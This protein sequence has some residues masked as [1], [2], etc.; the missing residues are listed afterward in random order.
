M[1]QAFNDAPLMIQIHLITALE[2]LIIGPFILYRR[3]RDRLHKI[4]GYIWVTNMAITSA[5]SLFIHEMRVIGAFS[6]IHLTSVTTLY[7]LW[8]SVKAARNGN[9]QAHRAIMGW[10]YWAGLVLAGMLSFIPGRLLTRTLDSMSDAGVAVF[11]VIC[12]GFLGVSAW[13]GLSQSRT[14]QR[15]K[16]SFA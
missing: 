1:L 16:R 10:L 12:F 2:A 8:Q 6:P 11:F 13:A 14:F 7:F 15:W 4:L 3:K 5:V 9:L